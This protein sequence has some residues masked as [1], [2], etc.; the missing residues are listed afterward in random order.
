MVTRLV[1]HKGLDLVKYVL[2]ELLQEDIQFVVLGSG[3][4]T[5]E[6]TFREMQE[7]EVCFPSET[8]NSSRRRR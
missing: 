4:W 1:S 6:N 3:D 2:D 7:Q 8:E 5:Y